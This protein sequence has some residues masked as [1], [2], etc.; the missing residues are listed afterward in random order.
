MIGL[1]T[2]LLAQSLHVALLELVAPVV[3]LAPFSADHGAIGLLLPLQCQLIS[4]RPRRS[5]RPP[6]AQSHGEIVLIYEE[7]RGR[8]NTLF[9]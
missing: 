9:W 2:I 7:R 1:L 8:K 6:S 3:P 4:G 5:H